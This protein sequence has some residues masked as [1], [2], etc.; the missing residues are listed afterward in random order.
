MKKNT[1]NPVNP[2]LENKFLWAGLALLAL[3]GI[4]SIFYFIFIHHTGSSENNT[5]QSTDVQ[6]TNLPLSYTNLQ[7][8]QIVSLINQSRTSQN[9]AELKWITQLNDAAQARAEYM[10]K[11]NVLDNTTGISTANITATGYNVQNWL[12]ASG[13]G[14]SSNQ[15]AVTGLTTGVNSSFGNNPN[16]KDIG[17]G[18]AAATISG[19]NEDIVV[20]ILANQ[21]VAVT[22]PSQSIDYTRFPYCRFN[23]NVP[24]DP[25]CLPSDWGGLMPN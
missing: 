12:V 11:N 16:Y 7:A 3:L 18:V 2:S 13:W 22:V 5:S 6:P 17:V 20:V 1:P 10:S 24:I 9:I 19:V 23:S 8:P 4:V 14:Y 25:R 15:L 21:A